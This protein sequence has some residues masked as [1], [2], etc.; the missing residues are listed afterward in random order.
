M[1]EIEKLKME[2]AIYKASELSP[3]RAAQV[4]R[5]SDFLGFDTAEEFARIFI[6]NFEE[7]S[8]YRIAEKAQEKKGET[9]HYSEIKAERERQ[10]E[11]WGKQNHHPLLWFSIIGEEYGEMCAAFNE[12]TF[13]NCEQH[14]R[15]MKKEAIQTAACCVAMLEC[16]D[17]ERNKT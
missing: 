12:Y 5:V 4:K 8:K 6:S 15:D 11:K 9:D 14:I 1:D 17:R 3:E 13:D 10:D 16:I 7:L 2:L